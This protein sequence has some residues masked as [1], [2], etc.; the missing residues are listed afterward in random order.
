MYQLRELERKDLNIINKWRN[1]VELI[2]K[3]GVPFRFINFDVDVSWYENYIRNRGNVIRCAIVSVDDDEILGLVSLTTIDSINQSAELHIMIENNKNQN[4]GIGSFAINKM[5]Q[6]AFFNMNLHRVELT[7]LSDN[8]RARHVYEKCG[9][10]QEGIKRK[11][12][13]KNGEFVDTCVYA[14]LKED[15][16][17]NTD[18]VSIFWGHQYKFCYTKYSA[19]A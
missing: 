18:K 9:F 11:S 14:I 12:N 1:D 2:E 3:F 6:H 15:F 19:A 13:F 17:A 16:L 4:K 10:K 8:D 7:V 5:L